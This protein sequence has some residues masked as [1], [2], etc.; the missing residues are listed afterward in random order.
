MSPASTDSRAVML[1]GHQTPAAFSLERQHPPGPVSTA[2]EDN[3][4]LPV[5][6]LQPGR[7]ISVH[8]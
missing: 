8:P 3:H 2:T 5:P 7:R 6:P 4:S 1:R